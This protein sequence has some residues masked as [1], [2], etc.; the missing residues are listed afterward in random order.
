MGWYDVPRPIV[1]DLIVQ[2]GRNQARKPALL[3]GTRRLDWAEF[4]AATNRVANGL[5]HLDLG[6][7]RRLAVL[8]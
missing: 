2:H 1:P 8:M 7:G 5:L 3:E 6:P 4:D